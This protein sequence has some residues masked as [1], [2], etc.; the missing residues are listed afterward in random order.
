MRASQRAI[1]ARVSQLQSAMS[2][3][4]SRV[5]S[6]LSGATA[7]SSPASTPTPLPSR[8]SPHTTSNISVSPSISTD[9]NR[10]ANSFSPNRCILGNISQ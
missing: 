4:A 1:S 8:R 9:G 6:K 5:S 10:N 7:K 2:V 3:S